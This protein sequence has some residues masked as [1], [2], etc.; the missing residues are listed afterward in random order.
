MKCPK[1]GFIS[2]DYL[3][4]CKKCGCDLGEYKRKMR[5]GTSRPV[6][7]PPKHLAT[8]EEPA[9]TSPVV[10][11]PP[12]PERKP[13]R[14]R[15]LL[16]RDAEREAAP[17][18]RPTEHPLGEALRRQGRSAPPAPEP[19]PSTGDEAVE[20]G[21]WTEP[22][23][24]VTSKSLVDQWLQNL[25]KKKRIKEAATIEELPEVAPPPEPAIRPTPPVVP[26]DEDAP[27][28]EAV[29]DAEWEIGGKPE[30]DARARETSGWTSELVDELTVPDAGE[31][32]AEPPVEP[33]PEP[34]AEPPAEP[35]V[36]DETPTV[37]MAP[38]VEPPAEPEPEPESLAELSAE[39]PVADETPTVTMAPEVEPIAEPP[40]EPP[41]EDETPTVTMAPEVE[42]LEEPSTEPPVEPEPEPPAEPPAE[43]PVEDE[44]PTV[45]MAPEVEYV[46][47]LVEKASFLN[48]TTAFVI[49]MTIITFVIAVFLGVGGLVMG[50]F[51]F[52]GQESPAIAEYARVLALPTYLLLLLLTAAYFVFFHGS[53]GQTIGKMLVGARV[54]DTNGHDLGYTRAFLRYAGWLF[55]GAFF[56][57]GH[58]WA[59]FDFNNQAWH[60][61]LAHSCDIK[62]RAGRGQ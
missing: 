36:E 49:D 9:P 16:R 30:T 3:D 54:M 32:P 14:L 11:K 52:S 12:A 38:E 37:T 7:A 27:V 47:E 17:D 23:S 62:S 18:R 53:S 51:P 34:P 22:E 1:C 10:A 25:G 43:P 59:A 33:E 2:F 60:D 8:R 20:L 31:P 24:P 13:G 44:T 6:V 39:P 40:A 5:I 56:F 48:R 4:R 15:S 46:E 57:L 21:Q 42:P 28:Q 58:V 55:S 19:A 61:K 29:S 41:V 26:P 45:T 50:V 35:P